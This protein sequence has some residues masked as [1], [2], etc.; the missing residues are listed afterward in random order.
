MKNYKSLKIVIAI[1]TIALCIGAGF[2]MGVSA[3]TAAPKI[4]SQN[5]NYGAD[6]RLMYAVDAEGITGPVTLK[7]YSDEALKTLVYEETKDT[8]ESITAGGVTKTVYKF[9]TQAIS[10]LNMTDCF[11][12]TASTDANGTSAPKRYSIAEYL[13]Q[14]LS[15]PTASDAQIAL[16]ESTV[17]YGTNL[18]LVVGKLDA[19]KDADKL[20]SNLRYVV[21]EGGTIDG[22]SR[23]VCPKGSTQTLVADNADAAAKW[24][25]SF[26]GKKGVEIADDEINQTELTIPET[27]GLIKVGVTYQLYKT[28]TNTFDDYLTTDTLSGKGMAVSAGTGEFAEEAGRGKVLKALLNESGS[29]IRFNQQYSGLAADVASA[30]EI[31]FDIKFVNAVLNHGLYFRIYDEESNP[32]FRLACFP[33]ADGSAIIRLDESSSG[34]NQISLTD[35]KLNGWVNIKF[36]IYESDTTKCYLSINGNEYVLP[37]RTAYPYTFGN[38]THIRIVAMSSVSNDTFIVDNLFAGYTTETK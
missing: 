13:Y 22:Y 30:Y 8:T 37:A 6:Y 31:S 27:E 17:T 19:A 14:R 5:I 2:A 18:Q 15:D 7:V 9:T 11:Y 20:I 16:Y 1:L 34:G 25:F 29:M 4:I 24:T 3:E 10:H 12:V 35:V 23:G 26:T 21:V 36:V 32:T 33:A 38:P 28:G